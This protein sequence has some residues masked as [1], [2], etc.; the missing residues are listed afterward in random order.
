M[1]LI[2]AL[3]ALLFIG[4]GLVFAALNHQSVVTDFGAFSAQSSLGFS[5]LVAFLLG[6]ILG[7][8][9]ALL[10]SIW[11]RRQ[12]SQQGLVSEATPSAHD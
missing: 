10:A 2:K 9:M 7:G 4:L 12:R 5:L 1:R 3:A 11:P 8:V 6:V